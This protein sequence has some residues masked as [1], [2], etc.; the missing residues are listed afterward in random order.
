MTTVSGEASDSPALVLLKPGVT[1]EQFG[2]VVSKLG[3]DDPLDVID[4]Y[5]T[6]VFSGVVFKGSAREC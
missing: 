5:A 1:P 4:T 6:I 2:A 3:P